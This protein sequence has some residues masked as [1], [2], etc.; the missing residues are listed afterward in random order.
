[1]DASLQGLR[2]YD[3]IW[4][5]QSHHQ[6]LDP[7]GLVAAW[8]AARHPLLTEAYPAGIALHAFAQRYRSPALAGCPLA[9]R[10]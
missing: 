7:D 4:L 5:V 2:D 8:F 6:E 9:C 1:V 3:T 10:R